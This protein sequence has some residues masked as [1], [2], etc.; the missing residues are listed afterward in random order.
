MPRVPWEA[1]GKFQGTSWFKL[2][3]NG[4][5]YEHKVDNLGLNFPQPPVKP[6]TVMDLVATA[7]PPSP[8]LTFSSGLLE[9]NF[10]WGSSSWL[11]LYCAV[12]STLEQ[13]GKFPLEIGMEGLVTCS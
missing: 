2:D 7:C 12:R 1:R 9:D 6:I 11:E 13:R 8:N 10:S 3:R 5:I 4:K